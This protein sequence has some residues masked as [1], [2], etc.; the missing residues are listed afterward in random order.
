MYFAIVRKKSIKHKLVEFSIAQ[1]S[2]NKQRI[3]SKGMTL[4]PR[5]INEIIFQLITESGIKRPA[6]FYADQVPQMMIVYIAPKLINGLSTIDTV[7]YTHLSE[8]TRR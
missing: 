3:I 5:F 4:Y 8:P 6:E 2:I 7:S 1:F